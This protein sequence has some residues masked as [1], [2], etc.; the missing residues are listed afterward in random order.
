MTRLVLGLAL[1]AA[2]LALG[3]GGS[4]EAP[5][6]SPFDDL[7]AVL[8]PAAQVTALRS[9]PSAHYGGTTTF[10]VSAVGPPAAAAARD[11]RPHRDAVT[12]RTDVWMDRRGQYRLVENNDQDGGRQVVRYEHDLSVAL[13]YGKMIRRP[14][15]EPEPTLILQEALGGP[16][17]AWETV[18]RFATV[19]RDSGGTFHLGRADHARPA[20]RSSTEPTALKRW[21]E[22]VEVQEL[23]GEA[24]LEPRTGAL[25]SFAIKARFSATREDRV[26]VAGEVAVNARVDGIGATPAITPPKAEVLEP[27]PRSILE[28]RALLGDLTRPSGGKETR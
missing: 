4:S 17:A 10:R 23:S 11:E 18:R 26:P 2:G 19:T 1:G 22:S 27:R 15:L 28:E 21:R 25:L 6:R 3:C 14:A 16:W 20:P 7:D 12:T 9:L 24:R 13:R 8:H 5:A